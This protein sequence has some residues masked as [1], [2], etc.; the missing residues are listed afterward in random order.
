VSHDQPHAHGRL[1]VGDDQTLHWEAYGNPDGAPAVVLHGGPGSGCTPEQRRWFDAARHRVVLFDQRGCGRSTPSAADPATSL[2]PITTDHMVADVER[3]R[4]HLGFDRW[5]V[6]GTSWGS[7]LALAYAQ[8]HPDRVRALVLAPVTMTRRS[9][10]DW[11][12]DGVARFLPAEHERFRAG[13]EGDLVA[14]YA[15]RLHDPDAAVRQHAADEFSRWELAVVGALPWP[16]RWASP[17]FRYGRARIVTHV[18]RHGA[19]LDDGALLRD[20]GIPGVLVHGRLDLGSPLATAWEL[21]CA[22]P[23]GELVVVEDAGHSTGLDAAILAATGR[24]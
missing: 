17:A 22:W 21:A 2:A 7:T 14:A 4:A 5:L 13:I 3:L 23:D 12:Y 1:D 11:L 10:I 19:W 6:L 20:P 16:G 18:F 9:E 15:E 24:L 8:R